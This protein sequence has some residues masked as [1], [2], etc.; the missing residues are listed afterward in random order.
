MGAWLGSDRVGVV[1]DDFVPERFAGV[2][3]VVVIRVVLVGV[4]VVDGGEV[5]LEG[6]GERLV[7]DGAFWGVC[8]G[9]DGAVLDDWDGEEF[10]GFG[11]EGVEFDAGEVRVEPEE[12]G[13]GH[14]VT[15]AVGWG[16]V[17]VARGVMSRGR[18][19][20]VVARAGEVVHD[21]GAVAVN[22]VLGG[23]CGRE[24]D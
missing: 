23:S 8:G 1:D 24:S 20:I 18:G 11:L 14:A 12:D 6:V 5:E 7:G 3:E 22:P 19:V 13:V 10:L 9:G 16:V 17:K 15:G 2:D 4:V 21:T